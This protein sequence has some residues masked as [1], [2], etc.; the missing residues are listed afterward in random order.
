MYFVRSLVGSLVPVCDF[1]S[2]NILN[3]GWT[4]VV[5]HEKK[6]LLSVQN[7]LLKDSQ[8][9]QITDFMHTCSSG[10]RDFTWVFISHSFN[11]RYGPLLSLE[12]I[13]LRINQNW[14]SNSNSHNLDITQNDNKTSIT[15]LIDKFRTHGIVSL[16]KTYGYTVGGGSML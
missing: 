13:I 4:T 9:E 11:K 2:Y 15:N 10:V 5:A 6:G 3:L 1:Q 12:G 8:T 7:A 14:M 16:P